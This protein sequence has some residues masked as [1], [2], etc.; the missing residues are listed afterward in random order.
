MN[1]Q[2][3]KE[4]NEN[5][6]IPVIKTI[7]RDCI[8]KYDNNQSLEDKTSISSSCT[9]DRLDNSNAEWN[10]DGKYWSLNYFCNHCRNE[11]WL[12]KNNLEYSSNIDLLE[13]IRKENKIYSDIIILIHQ[14]HLLEDIER[15]LDKIQ[16]KYI[17]KVIISVNNQNIKPSYINR[18]LSKYHFDWQLVIHLEELSIKEQLYKIHKYTIGMFFIIVDKL[19]DYNDSLPELL[20]KMINDDNQRFVYYETNEGITNLVI[21]NLLYK[22]LGTIERDIIMKYAE[23]Q[24]CQHMLKLKN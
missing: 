10:S 24:K 9:I 21:H 18:L 4:Q 23:E 3:N 14:N 8:F 17:G 1:E 20:D 22:M 13:K 6:Y 12:K 7:C 19:N 11:D 5:I 16:S 15:L 2:M